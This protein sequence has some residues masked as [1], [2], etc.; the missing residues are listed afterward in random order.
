MSSNLNGIDVAALQNFAEGVAGDAG[1][2]H[3]SFNVKTEWKGQTRSVAKVSRY[4]LAGETYS[5]NFEIAADEPNELLGENTAPNPQELLMAALN[6][7]MSVGYA[8]N[9]AMMG[10]KIHSLEI[11]TDGTL[12]LRGFLGIDESVNPGYDEV[13]VVIRLHTDASR[14]R[15]EEL[16][17]V[18]LKTSVN[19][20]NFSKAIRMLP[21]LEVI[22]G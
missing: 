3:A 20:A 17:N 9:A 19:Y 22:E 13:S 15:V 14:E 21:K 10:I 5:R 8:A 12:D 2:R 6:A 16:H 1:K 18:V 4:S 11:E 7:C